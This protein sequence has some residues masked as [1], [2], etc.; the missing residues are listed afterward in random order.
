MSLNSPVSKKTPAFSPTFAT[1]LLFLVFLL[2]PSAT[3][4]SSASSPLDFDFL[5]FFF[6]FFLGISGIIGKMMVLW[7]WYPGCF[8]LTPQGAHKEPF[9]KGIWY[10]VYP[11]NTHYVPRIWGWLLRA[12]SQGVPA[13]LPMTELRLWSERPSNNNNTLADLLN[14]TKI[15]TILWKKWVPGYPS[16]TR[17][18]PFNVEGEV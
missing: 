2:A 4:A 10:T 16:W 1:V 8:C 11:T 12:P 9:K 5:E 15:P 14:F 3:F 18:R 6:T 13:I 17:I 7:G